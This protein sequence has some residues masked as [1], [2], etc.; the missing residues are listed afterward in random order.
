MRHIA[1]VGGG[2]SGTLCAISLLNEGACSRLT[3]IEKTERQLFAGAAYAS[4]L[5]H[6]LLNVPASGMSLFID[7]PDHFVAWLRHSGFSDTYQPSDFVP[8]NLFGRYVKETFH[9]L[10]ALNPGLVDVVVGCVTGIAPQDAGYRVTVDAGTS[11][12]VDHVALCCGNLPSQNPPS[13]TDLIKNHPHYISTVWEGDY[14][15]L[16][17]KDDSLLI[18]GAG[19]TMVDQVL[20]LRQLGHTGK[21]YVTS[22]RGLLPLPH[23]PAP[24]YDLQHQRTADLM[25]AQGTL[26]WLRKEVDTATATGHS[27]ISVI[28][29]IRD[30]TPEIWMNWPER[31]KARFLRHAKPYW[32][33]H[34]HRIPQSSHTAIRDMQE[35]GQVGLVAGRIQRITPVEQGFE[36]VV[37]QK[38]TSS[39]RTLSVDW[40]CNCTGPHAQIRRAGDVLINQMLDEGLV[41]SDAL[42]LGIQPEVDNGGLIVIGPLSKGVYWEST[43][44]REI[45]LQAAE[46]A[47]RLSQTGVS[48]GT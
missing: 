44:L 25:T 27:W 21:I 18:V 22:R 30:L 34:R 9:E 42:G 46:M 35:S 23:G 45:R 15:S 39:L 31:E 48:S 32:E 43:A 26:S 28:N 37:Q 5:P 14:V 1:I 12:T 24:T 3:I 17:D 20:S 11:I 33:I 4:N 7:Q 40:I 16:V 2:L 29:A 36:V 38:T 13:V 19:L 6:Q 10:T 8:R 47:K 41:I